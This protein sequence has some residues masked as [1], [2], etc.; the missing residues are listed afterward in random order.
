MVMPD[1]DQQDGADGNGGK[2]AQLHQQLLEDPRHFERND[3][4]GE[5]EAEDGVAEAFEA[6]DFGAAD[7]ESGV[8]EAVSGGVGHEICFCSDGLKSMLAGGHDTAAYIFHGKG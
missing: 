7:A 8:I 1:R 3:Q 5:R 2:A 6:V 4:H